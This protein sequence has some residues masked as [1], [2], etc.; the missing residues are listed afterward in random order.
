LALYLTLS[1]NDKE[2]VVRSLIP[3]SICKR[4]LN[5]AIARALSNY[6]YHLTFTDQYHEAI[7][8]IL[9]AQQ[10]FRQLNRNIEEA[11]SYSQLALAYQRLSNFEKAIENNLKI[12]TYYLLKILF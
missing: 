2:Q 9:K 11:F 1:A 6:G 7:D 8:T 3:K 12:N 4:R 10:I 5:T